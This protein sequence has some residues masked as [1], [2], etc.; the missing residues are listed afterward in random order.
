MPPPPPERTRLY[1]VVF[2]LAAVYNLCFGV[3]T[4]LWPESYFELFRMAPPRYPQV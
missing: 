4:G 1:R 3:W 2:A